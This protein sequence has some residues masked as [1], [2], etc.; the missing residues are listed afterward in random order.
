MVARADQTSNSV[1]LPPKHPSSPLHHLSSHRP[2]TVS[3]ISRFCGAGK[4]LIK[5]FYFCFVGKGQQ[6]TV[7]SF[8]RNMIT[9]E[10]FP[11]RAAY[12]LHSRQD[13]DMDIAFDEED[14]PRASQVTCPGDYLTSAQ[15]FMRYLQ[16]PKH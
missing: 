7:S 14:K 12:D 4:T 1:I 11:T 16:P 5:P 6:A 9:F 8:P 13:E 3:A 10:S 15:V 2:H